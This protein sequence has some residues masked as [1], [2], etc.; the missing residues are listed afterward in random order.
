MKHKD[1][2]QIE[3]ENLKAIMKAIKKLEGI[4]KKLHKLF[5]DEKGNNRSTVE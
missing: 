4:Q 2:N 3:D 5:K 1:I